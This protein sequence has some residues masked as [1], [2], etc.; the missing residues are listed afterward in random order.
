MAVSGPF[1]ISG[2]AAL[3]IGLTCPEPT[4]LCVAVPFLAGSARRLKARWARSRQRVQLAIEVL[5]CL[6]HAGGAPPPPPEATGR[7]GQLRPGLG[8]YVGRRKPTLVGWTIFPKVSSLAPPRTHTG[9]QN[10]PLVMRSE[11]P[12]L[13]R[14]G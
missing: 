3:S 13:A 2:R 5:T 14:L 9:G 7:V 11:F 8:I 12:L 4:H 1:I 10:R 6:I